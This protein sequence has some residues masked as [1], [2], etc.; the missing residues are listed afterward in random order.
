MTQ[1]S[2]AE[3]DLTK[4]RN[5]VFRKV[6]RN[7]YLF[8]QIEKILKFLNTYREFSG[9]HSELEGNLNKRTNEIS[10]LNMGP[11][12]G[13]L[14]D[15]IYSKFDESERDHK[16]IKESYLSFE[17]RIEADPDFIEN[18]KQA[19]KSF[20]DERN[21]LIHHLFTGAEINTIEQF[22]E[23]EMFLD[24][25]RER[26]IIEHDQLKFLVMTI[27]DL[28][29]ESSDYFNSDEGI[30]Q[31]ELMRLQQS[32]LVRIL[33]EVTLKQARSDGWTL[34]NHAGNELRKHIPEEMNDL[35][36]MYGYQ[37][38]KATIIASEMFELLEEAASQG[39]VRLLY[40]PKPDVL[41]EYLS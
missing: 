37:T 15:N 27:A 16:E 7:V 40:R 25:Q 38:L 9:Y 23:L 10:K 17:F 30:K 13:Q 41:A 28:A 5:E 3:D 6:G 33:I 31:L 14:I 4:A 21:H 26:I 39:G 8:Q 22:A 18:R 2:E 34:L 32:D 24:A 11:L 36:R 12:V 1:I 29:K 19:L 35:K 20:V